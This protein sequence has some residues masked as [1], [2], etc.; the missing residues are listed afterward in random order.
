MTSLANLPTA[1]S[2]PHWQPASWDDYVK[3]RDSLPEGKGRLFFNL[4]WMLVEMG[5][6]I[7]HARFNR[8]MAIILFIWCSQ[9]IAQPYDD[10]GGC[11]LEKEG[12]RSAS[13][14]AVIYL[15]GGAP[16]RQEGETRYIDL[17]RWR[18][19]DLVCEISDTSLATDLDEKKQIY[20]ALG[21]PEY[22]VVDAIAA[23]A[24]AFRLDENGRYQQIE[25]SIALAGLPILLICQ[26]LE[27]LKQGQ[28][29]SSAAQ[30]FAQ[31]IN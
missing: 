2:I 29:N 19:P 7:D 8:L 17:A 26:T 23:R 24:I 22:W 25:V 4:G 6:G 27:K 20:A 18:V 14:D 10:L 21:I 16:R 12:E 28:S 31:Q 13:P 15:G 9:K 30:W 1:D 11:V 3:L 5:E